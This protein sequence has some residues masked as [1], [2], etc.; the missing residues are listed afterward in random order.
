M[1]DAL[2]SITEK[3]HQT[4]DVSSLQ[5]STYDFI[6][7][8]TL[9]FKAPLVEKP[10]PTQPS[11]TPEKEPQKSH[12][13]LLLLKA[14]LERIYKDIQ[15]AI[16]IIDDEVHSSD[17]MSLRDFSHTKEPEEKQHFTHVT[18]VLQSAIV[19]RIA[20][21]AQE[22][23][24]GEKVLEGV[25]DGERMIGPDGEYY[26]VPSN[27]ASKSKLVE[28]DIMKLSISPYG[29]FL[30]KQIGP[31]ERRRVMAVLQQHSETREYYAHAGEQRWRVLTASVTYDRG[32]SGDE[33]VILVP[34]QKSSKWGAVEHIIKKST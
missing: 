34:K 27:Y 1:A 28:G 18:E 11:F 25:F 32:I 12:T 9:D 17:D 22:V 24:N 29:S 16:E 19:S 3:E 10:Q 4:E 20:S 23:S 31:I 7:L 26:T 15:K 30:Y 13:R 21:S 2:F 33:V 14:S 6:G 8:N 5:K